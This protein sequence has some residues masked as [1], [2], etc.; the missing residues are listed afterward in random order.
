ML[1]PR[2]NVEAFTLPTT[3]TKMAPMHV[4]HIVGRC[5]RLV[6]V[7]AAYHYVI[8]QGV[9]LTFFVFVCLLGSAAVFSALQRPWQGRPLPNSLLGP[10]VVNGGIMAFSLLL[11][12]NGLRNCGP[13][14]TILGEYAGAVLGA[15]STLLF[16]RNGLVWRRIGGLLAMCAAYYFLSQGWAMSSYSP[17]SFG[18]TDVKEVSVKDEEGLIKSSSMLLPAFSGILA[19][20]RR[21]ISRRVSTKNHA[22]KRLHAVTVAAASCFIFPFAMFKLAVG[23]QHILSE[24]HGSAA[25]A[26]VSTILFG[27]VLIFYVDTFVEDRLHIVVASPIHILVTG[28]GIILFEFIYGMDFSFLGFIVCATVL[29]LGIYEATATDPNCRDLDQGNSFLKEDRV[30]VKMST[31]PS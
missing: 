23:K 9:S 30:P 19:A 1:L 12:A 21:I 28:V 17:F 24:P 27:V 5:L 15:L 14:R 20:I 18:S 2:F 11:W 4:I 3:A 8:A 7:Y 13:V 29:G 22:K 16:S 6:S 26:Y 10:A 31:L 25:W